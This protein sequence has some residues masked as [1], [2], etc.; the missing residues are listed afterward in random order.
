LDC[1]T[2]GIFTL[3]FEFE[4]EKKMEIAK[5]AL[6]KIKPYLNV[7][8]V[9]PNERIFQIIDKNTPLRDA[10]SAI[11]K[12]LAENLEGLIEMIYL[13]GLINI[14]FADLK[15]ILAGQGR[16]AYLKTVRIKEPEKEEAA[17]RLISSR[18]YPYTLQGARGIL[19]NIVG[20]K[21]LQLSDVSRISKIISNSLN[22]NAKIIFGISQ[23]PK[24]Q[25]KIDLTI[26]ATGCNI[27]GE[28]LKPARPAVSPAVSGTDEPA[29]VPLLAGNGAGVPKKK[30][31]RKIKKS[32]KDSASSDKTAP[33]K[34]ER[35]RL[36]SAR[37]TEIHGEKKKRADVSIKDSVKRQAP[38]SLKPRP[39]MDKKEKQKQPVLIRR[40]KKAVKK[41]K[42]SLKQAEKPGLPVEIKDK[43]DKI[44]ERNPLTV[45]EKMFLD[46][47]YGNTEKKVRRNALQIKKAVED[48]EKE[49]LEK[50]K[51]WET[52]AIFRRK[53]SA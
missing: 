20:G 53:K 23:R 14:D 34:K 2:Y 4:G 10:L 13:P 9:I 16:L 29:R 46:G 28:F 17:K 15:T 52:P 18:F 3:P 39:E 27:K 44:S 47:I 26:L 8:S 33:K 30:T 21:N 7:Y 24:K 22:K 11:N 50:E 1:L 5:E 12:Q 36:D 49:L 41:I 48:E 32:K 51:A 43:T 42:I 25:D 31:R 40:D 37:K 6:L 45:K 38:K 19:Y 35:S